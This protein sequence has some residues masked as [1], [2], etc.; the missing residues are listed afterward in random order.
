MRRHYRLLAATAV[1]ASLAGVSQD[2]SAIPVSVTGGFTSFTT[3]LLGSGNSSVAL[4]TLN[5]N[6]FCADSSCAV[7]GPAHATFAPQTS[8]EFVNSNDGI[9]P[10]TANLV[11]FTPAGPQ[12]V[13]GTGTANRFLLGTLTY[14]NGIWSGD[15]T[16][17][18]TLTTHSADPLLDG[19]F[20]TDVLTLLLTP[21]EGLTPEAN[22]DFVYF[23]GAPTM[24]SLRAYELADSPTGSNTVT[25]DVFGYFDSLHLLAFM[26][27]RD[28]GFLDPGI[29]L[30]PTPVGVPEPASL[31]LL[32][33]GLLS[34][35]AA[36]MR[37]RQPI[38]IDF[39]DP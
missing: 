38:A 22:A 18:F 36:R 25:A 16:F 6:P 9:T 37:R 26:N 32:A 20:L 30:A 29:D 27:V 11:R 19:L 7:T 12:E 15:A 21:N 35:G 2:A 24:G 28:G 31:A 5:G 39:K 33:V 3:T 17:G 4:S 8:L 13:T 23:S 1:F 14:T 34:L 10:N